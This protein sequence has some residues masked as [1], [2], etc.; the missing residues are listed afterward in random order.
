LTDVGKVTVAP[1]VDV[2]NIVVVCPVV[3]FVGSIFVAPPTKV[4]VKKLPV[5]RSKEA[6]VPTIVRAPTV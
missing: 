3:I 5:L 6:V 1:T 4:R 2:I